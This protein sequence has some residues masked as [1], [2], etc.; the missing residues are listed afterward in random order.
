MLA[1]IGVLH[2]SMI[3]VSDL[4]IHF[5][6]DIASEF[7]RALPDLDRPIRVRV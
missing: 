1:E 7:E 3:A 6:K 4:K 2:E 5:V